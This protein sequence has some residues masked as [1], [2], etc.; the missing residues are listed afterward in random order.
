MIDD[1]TSVRVRF[2]GYSSASGGAQRRSDYVAKRP[3]HTEL[4]ITGVALSAGVAAGRACFYQP[5]GSAAASPAAGGSTDEQR[6]REALDWMTRR[7]EE[8]ARNAEASVGGDAAE[9]FRA[10]KLILEGPSLRRRLFAAIGNQGLDAEEAVTREFD[11]Y[12]A[13]LQASGSRYMQDRSA[14]LTEIQAGLLNHL[15]RARPHHYCRDEVCAVNGQCSVRE[16]HIVV[17]AELTSTL[18]MELDAF[19]EGFLVERGARD[20]HAGILVRALGIPAVSGVAHLHRRIPRTSRIL[21]DG[22]AGEVLVNP[23]EET[24]RRYGRCADSD[25]LRKSG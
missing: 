19:T 20:S 24:L 25:P 6:L 16:S 12:K 11:S 23:S 9:I 2:D 22:F 18:P 8:L 10:Y 4:R 1:L 13:Q 7:Q 3:S 21:I 17:A 14:D 15:R 5:T